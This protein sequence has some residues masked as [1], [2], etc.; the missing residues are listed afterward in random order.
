MGV[1]CWWAGGWVMVWYCWLGLH[2]PAAPRVCTAWV[3]AHACIC[4]QPGS[5][6]AGRACARAPL[7]L[8]GQVLLEV[9]QQVER[10]HRAAREK[11]A[12]HPVRLIVHLWR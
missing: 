8:Q 10:G 2:M 12:R 7:L 5:C 4:R 11:V 6:N 1:C 9:E 3:H